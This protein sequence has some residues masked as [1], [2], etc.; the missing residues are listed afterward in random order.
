MNTLIDS[1]KQR[2]SQLS[3][4]DRSALRTGGSVVAVLLVIA[5]VIAPAYQ[6]Y[7]HLSS[8]LPAM[9]AQLVT[10]QAQSH[11]ARRLQAAPSAQ[12]Q[13]ESILSVLE[14]STVSHGIKS[15]VQNMTPRNDHS[16]SIRLKA[17]EYETFLKWLAGLS[18]QYQLRVSEAEINRSN[19]AG[20]V[21]AFVVIGSSK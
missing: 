10:M 2:W 14:K 5:L 18:S 13:N 15:S 17:V 4:A 7:R 19:A 1:L 12:A 6:S 20:I 9:R 16:A 8:S 3:D 11:E 21:D